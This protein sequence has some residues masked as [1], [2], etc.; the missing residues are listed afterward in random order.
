MGNLK[1]SC[2]TSTE[3]G[4]I[5]FTEGNE[6]INN[7]PLPN[8]FS[9]IQE[10]TLFDLI[11]SYYSSKNIEIQK[12]TPQ[13]FLKLIDSKSQKILDEY[14]EKL[15]DLSN[16][17]SSNKSI[18]PLKFINKDEENPENI[19]S[20]FYYEGE[21]NTEGVINGKGTK[22]I[23]NNLIYKGEFLNEKYHGKGIL[24][25]NEGNLSLFGQWENG[26]CKG[27][28]IYKVEDEFEY[29]GN[30]ENNKK[31]GFGIEKYN[32]GSEYEGNF[33]NNAKNGKGTYKFSN[34]EM[35]EGNFED[36]KYNGEGKYIWGIENK[37]YEGEFKNGIID[38]KG[39]YTY[40]D[41]SIYNGFFENGIKNGEGFIEFPDGKK[42]YGN[43]VNDELYGNGYLIT[44]N[45]R[46]EV[47][48]RHGKIISSIV[49][50]NEENNNIN[51]SNNDD[52]GFN[53]ECIKF[54]IN[55][56]SGDKNRINVN[57]YIC[58][59]CNC[60]FV[61]PIK[62]MGCSTNICKKCNG[63]IKCYN[64]NNDKFEDNEDLIKEMNENV[65]IK[66]NIC[67]KTLDYQEI[68]S[69]FH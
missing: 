2:F 14:E 7:N 16:L 59:R 56:F 19:F 64:C 21:F 53:S 30:F 41:G 15:D 6:N 11:S 55:S 33:V 65:K 47:I 40:N 27:K 67:E 28:V 10:E 31:N 37:Q 50:T 45:K 46:I 57:K 12:I 61:Q 35:Y 17:I 66:C 23:P 32:D 39:V 18:G 60:F 68:L 58:P 42:Y 38:G 4:Q 36:N 62:C 34:G 26:E 24:I 25:K 8:Q 22:I 13:E 49:N 51:L 48:F 69:H 3:N 20:I 54:N 5:T 63:G 44:N 29:E 52:N 9:I 43:W 1:C